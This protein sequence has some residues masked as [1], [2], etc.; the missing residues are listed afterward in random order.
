MTTNDEAKAADSRMR[1]LI[2]LFKGV[3]LSKK[4]EE[5]MTKIGTFFE[6][7]SLQVMEENKSNFSLQEFY[8]HSVFQ[9]WALLMTGILTSG[10]EIRDSSE[11]DLATFNM[12]EEFAT[13]IDG[14]K[15]EHGL[16][17]IF[18]TRSVNQLKQSSGA[19]I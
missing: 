12:K 19:M 4:Q 3:K 9:S 6:K 8:M 16:Q 15:R 2:T 13:L 10:L 11:V 18:V 5:A 1:K 7:A 17:E 14:L